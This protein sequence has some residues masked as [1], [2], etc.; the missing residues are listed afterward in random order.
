MLGH[1]FLGITLSAS[2]TMRVLQTAEPNRPICLVGCPS[3]VHPPRIPRQFGAP[4]RRRHVIVCQI[5]HCPMGLPRKG[6][7]NL[8]VHCNQDV[9]CIDQRAA[10]SSLGQIEVLQHLARDDGRQHFPGSRFSSADGGAKRECNWPMDS[11]R[12]CKRLGSAASSSMAMQSRTN[13]G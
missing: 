13:T 2:F 3:F 8:V 11:G 12:H 9:R 10:R 4:L 1:I 7:T 5:L 6:I